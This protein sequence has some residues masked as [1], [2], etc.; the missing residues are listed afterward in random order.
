MQLGKPW[1]ISIISRDGGAPQDVLAES[2]GQIDA[3]WS[4]DGRRI[5]FGYLRVEGG[6]SIRIVNLSTQEVT[7][8]PGSD[9]L[10]SPR[11]SPDG[12][13]IAA[14]SI[15]N[16]RLMLFDYKTRRW[17]TLAQEEGAGTVDLSS[18]SDRQQ[19]YII[20]YISLQ[21]KNQL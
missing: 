19:Q 10:F 11:W 7:T 15:D 16:T 6:G 18:C 17:S 12:R 8:V 20:L 4:R 9:G 21:T 5:M 14:L 3:N 2:H 13:Y 1:K